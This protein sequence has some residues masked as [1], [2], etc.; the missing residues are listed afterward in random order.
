M[1]PF[2]VLSIIRHLVLDNHP[3]DKAR[4]EEKPRSHGSRELRLIQLAVRKLTLASKAQ[5]S[6]STGLLLEHLRKGK[7]ALYKTYN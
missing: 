7:T 5:V 3:Y 1:V 2:W 6:T 4:T